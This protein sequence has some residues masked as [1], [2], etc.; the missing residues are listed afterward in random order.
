[1]H[2]IIPHGV[3]TVIR[4]FA[5]KQEGCSSWG[6][7]TYFYF[8]AHINELVQFQSEEEDCY[9]LLVCNDGSVNISELHGSTYCGG[10]TITITPEDWE[11]I[12]K[13]VKRQQKQI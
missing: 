1:M 6:W 8:M 5:Y 10:V 12:V 3:P 11:L 9:E 13:F 7:A 4:N 2:H